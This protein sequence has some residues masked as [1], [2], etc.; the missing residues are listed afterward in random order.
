MSLRT[1]E[2][3]EDGERS[4]DPS[5]C[6][7]MRNISQ[8]YQVVLLEDMKTGRK[9]CFT[10]E[11]LMRYPS[12]RLTK[13]LFKMGCGSNESLILSADPTLFALL[14]REIKHPGSVN[15]RRLASE[16]LNLVADY[17][18]YLR[19]FE[20]LDRVEE[21][22]DQKARAT[23]LI[24]DASHLVFLPFLES[25]EALSHRDKTILTSAMS[26]VVDLIN[27]RDDYDTF[28]DNLRETLERRRR[29]MGNARHA[30]SE[31]RKESKYERRD[32]STP[33]PNFSRN[34]AYED[35]ETDTNL[36]PEL[37]RQ[38]VAQWPRAN[39]MMDGD[40][41]K[42]DSKSVRVS[43]N[44]DGEMVPE[45]HETQDTRAPFN[46]PR[47]TNPRTT[48]LNTKDK[49]SFP[50]FPVR[51]LSSAGLL[52]AINGKSSSEGSSSTTLLESKQGEAKEVATTAP[53]TSSSVYGNIMNQIQQSRTRA[54][55]TTATSS[56]LPTGTCSS[57]ANPSSVISL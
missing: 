27:P 3:E 34:P 11:N 9:Y 5:G 10:Y 42:N 26:A 12:S 1:S 44:N 33:R 6:A 55:T 22:L 2:N 13:E 21:V 47:G 56:T 25:I 54:P 38:R 39:R 7:M 16:E 46:S 8:F 24:H 31:G 19:L 29:N 45:F 23:A 14:T 17:C 43:F 40:D 32:D 18:H 51:Y 50:S 37:S 48:G 52:A 35:R 36:S 20:I 4:H 30:A 28:H 53:A 15:W 49:L 41:F 57:I